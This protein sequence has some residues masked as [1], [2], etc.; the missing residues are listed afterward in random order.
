MSDKKGNTSYTLYLLLLWRSELAVISDNCAKEL[1]VN[2]IDR[3][4]LKRI[5]REIKE[6]YE[7]LG[8]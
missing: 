1:K 2:Y 5:A 8:V 3:L 7:E 4:K 6:L